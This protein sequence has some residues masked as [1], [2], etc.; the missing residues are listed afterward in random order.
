MMRI[1]L[2]ALA[3]AGALLAVLPVAAASHWTYDSG[4]EWAYPGGSTCYT[5]V[6]GAS[7][8]PGCLAAFLC[9]GGA[10][11]Q[12]VDLALY[13]ASRAA[14]TADDVVL[15]LPVFAWAY[16]DSA[17]ALAEEQPASI[18]ALTAAERG[19]VNTVL[20]TQVWSF[21]C[22]NPIALPEHAPL[23]DPLGGYPLA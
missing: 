7:V 9:T 13:C 5:N 19:Q 12:A 2:R 21:F 20:C 1:P 22:A 11:P 18:N 4:G 15:W 23:A 8:N 3:L 17:V 10:P 14:G 16:A 6:L